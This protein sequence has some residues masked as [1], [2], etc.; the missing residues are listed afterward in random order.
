MA[1]SMMHLNG[2]LL[3]AIDVETTGLK[4]GFHDIWQVAILPLDS[5]IKPLKSVLPFYMDIKASN[6]DRIDSKAIKLPRAEFARRQQSAIESFSCADLLDE[7]FDRL[8]LP[9]Y[10][11]IIPLAQNWPF[12]RSF[13]IAW[14]GILS[15]EHLF[16]PVYRDTMAAAAFISDLTD[17]KSE[18]ILFTQHNLAFLCAR[19]GVQNAKAHDALQ[20]AIATAE[21]YRRML[22]M[23][24]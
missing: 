17:F 7:W 6:P 20:D 22:L 23:S 13:L 24:V 21:C 12:D 11:R 4:P 5:N 10:K 9:L 2:H 19:L 14:L 8:K 3:C 15:F 18:K 16:F 1:Q